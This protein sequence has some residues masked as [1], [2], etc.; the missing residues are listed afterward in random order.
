VTGEEDFEGY[1]IYRST[2]PEFRDPQIITTGTGSGPLGN[3]KPIAQFDVDNDFAGYSDLAIEG[4]QY[5][6]GANTG[7][8]HTWT[9][10]SA[11]NGQ[12][13]YYAVTA[14]DR[15]SQ[16]F[17][18]YP[19]ENAIAPSRTPRGGLVLPT[20]VV[21]VRA[22]PR[23]LGY[24][25]AQADTPVAATGRGHGTIAI[26][27]VNS[28]LVP[29][30]HTFR[31][32]FLTPHPDSLAASHYSLTDVT[33][34]LTTFTTG[35]DLRGEGV[36]PVGLG[37]LPIIST[38]REVAVDTT[39]GFLDGSPTDARIT[40]AYERSVLPINRLRDG[41]P[42]DITIFFYDSVVDTSV[43]T[44]FT[45]PATPAKFEVIA[46]GPDGD[47]RL[48]FRF[49]DKDANRTFSR[50][51][52]LIDIV[53]YVDSAPSVPKV[54][55]R[56][57]LVDAPTLPPAAGDAWALKLIRPFGADDTFEF[58]TAGEYVQAGAGGQTMAP[59]VVPNP[60][61]GSA[62]FEPE[63]FA[64]SGRGERRIEFRG[65]ASSCVIRIYN[66]IGELVQTLRHDGSTDGTV[67]WDLRTKDE[68]D[69]A[70]GLY[71][72]HV[73]GGAAGEATGKFAI[74]K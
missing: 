3:G 45:Y 67:A 73:D 41:Y 70:P 24:M 61:L 28:G 44:G 13:Y 17:S 7:L 38:N 71:I 39:T 16:A 59:Y 51:D 66:L 37:L 10:N 63:R 33:A 26:E 74:V 15:G 32:G 30:E 47:R 35:A 53:T 22:E 27:I 14:Y 42:D 57:R 29:D 55:W 69:V 23:V 12:Q 54:T 40:V 11:V 5:Y 50:L 72:F 21:A 36:G 62:S 46:H 19:S 2:D 6:L 31:I 64:V 25:P 60:Y 48:D 8:T 9:D 1:R 49:V 56:L 34:D 18:F 52:E 4:V 20:N 68:L 43:S 65:L 58:T